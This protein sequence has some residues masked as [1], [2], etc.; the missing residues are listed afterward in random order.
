MKVLDLFSGLKG[1]SQAFEDRG[2]LVVTVDIDKKFNPTI[3]A[4]VMSLTAEDFESYGS[5]D[6]V[7]ASPPCNCFSIAS[8][9]RHWNK[10]TRRPK[11]NAT[12]KAI[13]LVGHTI[14][15]ILDLN[16]K[17]WILENPRG[18]LRNVLGLPSKTT[19]FA[20]WNHFAYKPTDLWGVLPPIEWRK[21]RKWQKAPRGSKSGTQGVTGKTVKA[22]P[23]NMADF[24]RKPELRAKIPYGLSL[25]VCLACEKELGEEK[26]LEESEKQ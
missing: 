5:F 1:W 8:V 12:R 24:V 2:H 3:C 18:M 25:A 6:L 19:F 26:L 7:L 14:K 23:S 22:W 9:Y 13:N 16:P 20:A 15:L 17:W 10:R 11:D 21:P 4:D